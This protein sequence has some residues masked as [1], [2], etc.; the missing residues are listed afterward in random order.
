MQLLAKTLARIQRAA[1]DEIA[2]L[3]ERAEDVHSIEALI[4][5]LRNSGIQVV[6]SQVRASTGLL[7]ATAL[8]RGRDYENTELMLLRAGLWRTQ[9]AGAHIGFAGEFNGRPFQLGIGCL[10]SSEQVAA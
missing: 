6:N 3:T 7:V 8:I 1:N 9:P 5:D 4:T 10:P 2:A